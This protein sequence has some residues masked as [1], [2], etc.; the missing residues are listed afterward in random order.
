MTPTHPRHRVYCSHNTMYLS[1]SGIP[2][3]EFRAAGCNMNGK[4]KELGVAAFLQISMTPLCIHLGSIRDQ[5]WELSTTYEPQVITVSV[6]VLRKR[7]RP[8]V[9][10]K[11]NLRTSGG[12]GCHSSPPHGASSCLGCF[13]FTLKLN[14][15]TSYIWTGVHIPDHVRRRPARVVCCSRGDLRSYCGQPGC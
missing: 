1:L 11:Y 5:T 8:D 6:A 3:A 10:S 9:G 13:E 14:L 4:D 15:Q 7:K 12:V 2:S